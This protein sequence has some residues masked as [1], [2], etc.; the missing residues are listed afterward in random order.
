[1]DKELNPFLRAFYLT[2]GFFFLILGIMGVML[3]VMPGTV[4]LIF[5]TTCFLK[6]SETLAEYM[7]S[8]KYFGKTIRDFFE[9]RSL[10]LKVKVLS[11]TMMFFP[12]VIYAGLFIDS[13]TQRITLI[14]SIS[15]A[16]IY[17]LSFKTSKA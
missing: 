9:T 1:M 2:G 8:N 6:S 12:S 4:F 5:A 14:L 7:M 16:T 17:I 10:P 3:P 15:I 13:W 11:S